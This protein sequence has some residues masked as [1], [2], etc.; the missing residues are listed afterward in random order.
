MLQEQELAG[1]VGVSLA[2]IGQPL[3]HVPG[4]LVIYSA[5]PFDFNIYHNWNLAEI[6]PVAKYFMT[7]LCELLCSRRCD[8]VQLF[9]NVSLEEVERLECI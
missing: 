5:V 3:L 8:K 6:R 1:Q 2:F 7:Y 4:F 9:L